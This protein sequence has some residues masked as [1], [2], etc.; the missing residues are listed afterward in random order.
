MLIKNEQFLKLKI[1]RYLQNIAGYN[2]LI[3]IITHLQRVLV[4]LLLKIVQLYIF[5]LNNLIIINQSKNNG[6]ITFQC[7]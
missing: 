4:I 3:I 6:S 5:I 1:R 7:F 2:D